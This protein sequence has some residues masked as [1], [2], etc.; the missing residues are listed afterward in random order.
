[1]GLGTCNAP[2]LQIPSLQIPSEAG[3]R[4]HRLK[5]RLD[6]G[7]GSLVEGIPTHGKELELYDLYGASQPK[8]FNDSIL[9]LYTQFGKHWLH[10][11]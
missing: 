8:P 11:P 2:S 4:L 5:A 6:G 1:M 3:S 7:L 9:I 10:Y